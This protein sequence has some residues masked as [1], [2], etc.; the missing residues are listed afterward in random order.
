ME[1]ANAQTSVPDWL[2]T[3]CRQLADVHYQRKLNVMYVHMLESFL[4]YEPWKATP[5]YKWRVAK[6]HPTGK[7]GIN[8]RDA[9]SGWFPMNMVLPTKLVDQV[10]A[11]IEVVNANPTSELTRSLSLRTFLYTAVCW[12]TTYVYPYNGPGMIQGNE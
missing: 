10:R 7:T 5:P 2:M 4:A 6:I 9:G 8:K 3:Y 1:H 11:A 12:W